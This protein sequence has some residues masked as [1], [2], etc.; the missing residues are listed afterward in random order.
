MP[1]RPGSLCYGLVQNAE[2][3]RT[4][5]VA[6]PYLAGI[7]PGTRERVPRPLPAQPALEALWREADS[8]AIVARMQSP[9]QPI[10]AALPLL[11]RLK[12]D[13]SD[14]VWANE[15]PL[16]RRQSGA[17][18]AFGRCTPA[19]HA[20]LV[21]PAPSTCWQLEG[22]EDLQ[23]FRGSKLVF[24][25]CTHEQIGFLSGSRELLTSIGAEATVVGA[26]P[27]AYRVRGRR[28]SEEERAKLLP[29]G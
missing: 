10:G 12:A 23:L 27:D 11:S 4:W 20:A 16:T 21:A 1:L 14:L 26:R 19:S 13:L 29:G 2:I 17:L 5:S 9:K 3:E 25:V 8:F 15:W 6:G 7:F 28:L 24:F 22:W 18:L